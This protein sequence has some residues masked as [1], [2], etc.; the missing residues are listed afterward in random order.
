[1]PI[2]P[3]QVNNVLRVY[4]DQLCQTRI[5]KQPAD[6]GA[7]EHQKIG[8]S[9]KTRREAIIDGI[10]SNIIKR[11]TQ[12]GFHDK[13]APAACENLENEQGNP[14]SFPK[15]RPGKII[16]KEIDGNAETINSLSLEDSKFLTHKL[17]IITWKNMK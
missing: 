10:A 17:S 6:A 15:D 11:I 3:H 13:A 4:G 5:S 1:M 12:S 7:G 8:I 9:A 16:F 14:A 2:S